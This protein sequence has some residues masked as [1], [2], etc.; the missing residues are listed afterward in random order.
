MNIKNRLG[1]A[2]ELPLLPWW[3]AW[4]AWAWPGRRQPPWGHRL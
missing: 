1:H 2:G 4:V 3:S